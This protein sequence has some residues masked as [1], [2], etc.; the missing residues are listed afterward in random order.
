MR[1]VNTGEA[2][3]GGDLVDVEFTLECIV[4]YSLIGNEI[5]L[6]CVA[7]AFNTQLIAYD[8]AVVKIIRYIE[9]VLKKHFRA[10]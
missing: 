1:A 6:P 3:T 9:M 2:K 5:L 4:F 7:Y 10:R 8:F